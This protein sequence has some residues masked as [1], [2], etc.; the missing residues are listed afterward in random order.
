[1]AP[2]LSDDIPID[3]F[4]FWC[5]ACKWWRELPPARKLADGWDPRTPATRCPVCDS[6]MVLKKVEP[7]EK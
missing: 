7:K 3:G 6:R 1:M 2:T 4:A 5:P